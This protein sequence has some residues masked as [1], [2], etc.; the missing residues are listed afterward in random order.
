MEPR[1]GRLTRQ[2]SWRP[3]PTLTRSRLAAD[4]LGAHVTRGEG[5][6]RADLNVSQPRLQT[7]RGVT[8]FSRS[9][10]GETFAPSALME[11]ISKSFLA[12]VERIPTTTASRYRATAGLTTGGGSG[13]LPTGTASGL[14]VG[15]VGGGAGPGLEG[16][17]SSDPDPS[18]KGGGGRFREEPPRRRPPP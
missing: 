2:G 18:W 1:R 5:I 15:V 6:D 3:G 11:P 9:H 8:A 7:A 4:V 10:R 12:A 14:D 16:S 17:A 13:A